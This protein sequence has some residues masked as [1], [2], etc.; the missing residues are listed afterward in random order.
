M[1]QR[2]LTA[3]LVLGLASA[4]LV[5]G[6]QPMLGFSE[7][8]AARQRDLE[9]RFDAQLE[10]QNL[11]DWMK[12]LAARPHHVGSPHGKANAQFMVGLFRSWG[13][14][15]RIEEFSVLFPTPETRVVE[16][17]SPT[18]FTAS[19][20]ET[21]LA[22]DSTSGQTA[23]QLPSYNA[24]SID[25][26]VTGELVYVNYGVPDDYEELERRGIS[27]E[28]RIVLARYG[29]S[30]RGI[31]PKVAAEH[32]AI[33]CILFSDPRDDGYFLG[34][35]Y[36]A[37]GWR[38]EQGAQRG[39]VADMPLYPGDPLTPFVGA[40]ADAERLAL[41]DTPTLT[42]IPV[43]P[44][45][46][47]DALPLLKALEGPV[48]PPAW[49]GALPVTYHLG[50]GPAT[51]HLKLKFDWSRAPAYDVIAVLPGSEFP[52]QWII[53]GNHH[54]AWVNGATDPVSGMVALLEEA[55]ALGE[56]VKQGWKPKRTIV[57]AAWDA[58]E[59]GLL[60]S[61]E[62]VELH[63]ETL[64]KKAVVYINTDSNARG[65]LNAGGSHTLEKLVN[66]V[67]RDV[68]DPQKG[69]SVADRARAAIALHGESDEQQAA[70]DGEDL[71]LY[72]LG[73]GSDYTPFLQHLGI[74]SLNLGFGGEAHYGQYHS[75]YDSFD[76]YSRFMD[77]SFQ[78]GVA[79]AQVAG[80]L[81]LRLADADV[82]PFDFTAFSAKVEKYAGEVIELGDTMR[83]ETERKNRLIEKQFYDAAADPTE[84]FVAPDPEDPVPHLGF[85]PL[86]NAVAALK[87]STAKFNSAMQAY[88]QGEKTLSPAAQA[89][90]NRILMT[91]ER[92]LTRDEGLPRRPWFVHHIYAPGF[93]TGYGVKTLPGVRE[94]IE[95]RKWQEAEQQI[96]IAAGVI[97]AF[98]KE[99]D[100]ATAVLAGTP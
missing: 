51:V 31:K 4:T 25:G 8:S 78:Y 60:G 56:L 12:R 35:V 14:D 84:P 38:P 85:A 39:S 69:I 23:E 49:R 55:R 73:S 66:Q 29:G 43:L 65:F 47:K 37:G 95:E 62:W 100:R 26:D 92:A 17:V 34:D 11:H 2:M 33:G 64:Q 71:P 30:W 99:V 59:P 46:Y 1:L 68:T 61:T 16:M 18:R 7:A 10:A 94:A 5:A 28:G 93:Y 32:G 36:P 22:E 77:P 40:T 50:P 67:A 86:K 3:V 89:D 90:L 27:V 76:H 72:P 63:A 45:S 52:D 48:A 91:T 83:K 19:L 24:Y 44:I 20:A 70:L 74:A 58:E 87:A 13:Y 81:V 6:D 96:E 80:R 98:A 41:E 82:L 21:T 15:A 79:L 88:E 9:S 97:T 75:V 54:D 42:K 57:Y 53:R